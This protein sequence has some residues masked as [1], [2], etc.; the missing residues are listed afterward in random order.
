MLTFNAAAPT[1]LWGAEGA[2]T[3]TTETPSGGH[4]TNAGQEATRLPGQ[5]PRGKRPSGETHRARVT[6]EAQ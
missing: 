3:H 5:T 6:V 1:Q 4:G 2:P